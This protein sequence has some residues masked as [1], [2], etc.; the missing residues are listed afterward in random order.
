MTFLCRNMK[1]YRT[2]MQ[3]YYLPDNGTLIIITNRM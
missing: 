3:L 2:I 1:T